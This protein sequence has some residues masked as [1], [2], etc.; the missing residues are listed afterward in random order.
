M[1]VKFTMDH[2]GI[3]LMNTASQDTTNAATTPGAYTAAP[4]TGEAWVRKFQAQVKVA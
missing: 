2:L 1:E 3:D 4:S